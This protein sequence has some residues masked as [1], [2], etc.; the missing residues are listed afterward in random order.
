MNLRRLLLACLATA[1]A[2]PAVAHAGGP[3]R[4]GFAGDEF[5]GA[6]AVANPVFSRF[7][8]AGATTIRL[9]LYW[10]GVAP[11]KPEHPANPD[12]PKYDW[13]KFDA[14]V[15]RAFRHG[16]MPV[17]TISGTPSWAGTGGE[18]R[19]RP[20]PV[21]LGFFAEAAAKR[22]NGSVLPD[23][24]DAGVPPIRHWQVWNEPNRGYFFYPQFEDG[25]LTSPRSYRRM[26][27]EVAAGVNAVD[28][29]NLVIAGGLAP[30]GRPGHPAPMRFMRKMLCISETRPYR[31]TCDLRNSKVAFDIWAH[32][33]YTSGGPTH[34]A[35][36]AD[37]VALGDLPEMR[38]LLMAAV[39][40][41]QVRAS[42]TVRFWVTEFSWDS[43][44]PDP[45]AVPMRLHA[46][47]V[48]E[49]LYRMWQSRISLVMW[50]LT[51]D[52]PLSTSPYQS[53]LYFKDGKTPKLSL[54][55]F[56]FPFVAFRRT[57]GIHVWGRTPAG[58]P[59]KVVVER[60]TPAGWRRLGILTT[61]AYGIF[62]KTYRTP[63]TKG[64]VRARIQGA[65]TPDKTSLAFSL[66]RVADRWVNPFGCGGD[67]PC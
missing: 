29:G 62:T 57:G 1:L 36:R 37:D 47:W 4:T 59:A 8:K 58:S 46:R 64:L 45:R 34:S 11:V 25:L 51:A 65:T 61:S 31:R 5:N 3:L 12:D 50:F 48:A 38:R 7:A 35:Y 22:Y 40:L 33:P 6:D 19:S 54:R 43:Y 67:I 20:D 27:N 14:Q 52:K 17:V 16:L 9:S 10:Y 30:L 53:G 60:R 15:V 23:Y 55:A 28:P 56:R 41:G 39:G 26:V 66:T 32:H 13:S 24:P 63:V 49:A 42:G 21:Q 18:I 2:V 44:K